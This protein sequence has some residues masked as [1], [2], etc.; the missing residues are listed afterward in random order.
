M[1]DERDLFERAAAR[2]DPPTD[3]FERFTDRQERRQRNRRVAGAVV[4]AIVVLL[5]AAAV[6]WSLSKTEED[7]PAP[8]PD[9]FAPVHGWIAR[10][11]PN[12]VEAIDPADPTQTRVLSERE[13]MPLAWSPDGSELL[14]LGGSNLVVLKSDGTET[15]VTDFKHN[16]FPAGG[17]FT[18]DGSAVVYE[19]GW[20]I[21]SVPVTG[22]EPTVLMKGDPP[23]Q[24]YVL[25][26]FRGD[27][28][29]ALGSWPTYRFRL[30]ARGMAGSG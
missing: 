27:S 20:S 6:L 29:P 17:S 28:S 22:G 23:S 8:P 16:D 10:G 9:V 4:S 21:Y 12:S 30:E 3:A 19:S 2:F 5:M 14:V 13:G 7:I 26:F 24:G 18:P 15:T 1:I 11:G 25:P